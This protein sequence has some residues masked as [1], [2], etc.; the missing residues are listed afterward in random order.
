MAKSSYVRPVSV[1]GTPD[2][3]AGYLKIGLKTKSGEVKGIAKTDLVLDTDYASTQAI[4]NLITKHGREAAAEI[5]KE[6]LVISFWLPEDKT[7]AEFDLES[8]METPAE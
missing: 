8:I 6:N 1:G 5:L 7:D 3:F 4:R 2:T